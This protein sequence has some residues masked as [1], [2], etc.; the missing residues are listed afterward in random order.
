MLLGPIFAVLNLIQGYFQLALI[1]LTSM[2]LGLI[3]LTLLRKKFIRSAALLLIVGGGVIYFFSGLIFH[4]GTEYSLLLGMLGGAFM[5][6]SFFLRLSLAVFNGA[7]FLMIKILHHGP[8]GL[9]QFPLSRYAI[10]ILILLLSYYVILEIVRTVDRNYQRAIEEKNSDLA[11]SRRQLDEEHAELMVRTSQL[12]IAN[13]AKEKLFSIVAHD[14]RGPIGSLKSSIECLDNHLLTPAEFQAMVAELKVGVD[15]AYECLDNLLLWSA[16]QLR[17][18]KPIFTEVPLQSTA[19]ESMELL[20][21]MAGYKNIEI[22]NSIPAEALVWADET[23]VSS[24][25]RNLVSNALKYTP[26]G[27]LVEISAVNGDGV[28]RVTV[29]D[30]GVG[31]TPEQVSKLFESTTANSTVGTDKERGF[32]LG[33]QICNEFIRSNGG[34]LTVESR[35]GDGTSFHFTLRS[36]PLESPTGTRV[37]LSRKTDSA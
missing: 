22:C 15:R 7:G 35:E 32:G 30:N 28:W 13:R 23:Q 21:D 4:N 8:T 18:I 26:S 37:Q 36:M 11:E 3:C 25:F 19:Q 14:I 5:F 1:N 27:G 12:Q 29:A 9:D 24:I 16:G 17:E 2:F 31:M 33:L 34:T 10:N 6:E 20:A